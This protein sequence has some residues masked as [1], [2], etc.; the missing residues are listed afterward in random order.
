MHEMDNPL[1]YAAS[2][3]P[4]YLPTGTLCMDANYLQYC[5]V[6][7]VACMLAVQYSVE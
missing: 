7:A 1:L 6:C 4:L 5:A 2:P 3:W